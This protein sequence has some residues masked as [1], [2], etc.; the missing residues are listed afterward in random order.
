MKEP[1]GIV[2][3]FLYPIEVAAEAHRGVRTIGKY[4]WM[5]DLNPTDLNLLIEE[6]QIETERV[7]TE[8]FLN[9]RIELLDSFEAWLADRAQ[10][11]KGDVNPIDTIE[12]EGLA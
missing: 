11:E 5:A 3:K 4:Q 1:N 6:L 9:H 12:S 10:Q 8:F 7:L 2:D